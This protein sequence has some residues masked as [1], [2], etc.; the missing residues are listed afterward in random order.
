MSQHPK[1]TATELAVRVEDMVLVGRW[2]EAETQ[3]R[4]I[5][6]YYKATK[7]FEVQRYIQDETTRQGNKLMWEKLV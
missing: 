7:Y 5:D 1:E 3:G 2:P 6:L 4:H